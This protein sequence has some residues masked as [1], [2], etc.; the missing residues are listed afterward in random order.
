MKL[1]P[2]A[3]IRFHQE[4]KR[5]WIQDDVQTPQYEINVGYCN[6]ERFD[7]IDTSCCTNC[8]F[9]RSDLGS[10][11]RDGWYQRKF[12]AATLRTSR[13]RHESQAAVLLLLVEQLQQLLR[14]CSYL[15]CTVERLVQCQTSVQRAPRSKK[16]TNRNS[17]CSSVAIAPAQMEFVLAAV[18][19]IQKM[20]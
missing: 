3:Q 8:E 18:D 14:L 5:R 6:S 12:C 17:W 13:T 1:R 10:N 4:T 16:T 11:V 9:G 19:V 20:H 15:L 7:D 2:S